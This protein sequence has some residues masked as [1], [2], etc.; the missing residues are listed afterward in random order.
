M[1]SASDRHVSKIS[2]EDYA[3]LGKLIVQWANNPDS[4]PKT[5]ADA[6][7]LLKAAGINFPQDRLP[8]DAPVFFIDN[9]LNA[10]VIKLPQPEIVAQALREI[11]ENN[12]Q[13]PAD[14]LPS[15]LSESQHTDRVFDL[16]FY[17]ST[18]GQYSV[19]PNS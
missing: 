6:K 4:R 3:A 2:V 19:D 9:P 16:N 15:Y 18:I 5:I 10:W 14:S 11:A 13:Y 17:Y 7:P 8:D 12:G 1:G